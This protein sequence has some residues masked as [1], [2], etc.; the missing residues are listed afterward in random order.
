[1]INYIL[2]LIDKYKIYIK[3][4]ISGGTAAFV[5]LVLLYILTDIFGIWYLASASLA[6][7]VAFFVSFYLQKFWTFRDSSRDRM[8]QQMSIY[9]AVG[10]TNVGI[11]A[12]GM[13][14]LVDILG[15]MYI[16]AQIIMGGLIAIGSFLMYKFVIF[17]K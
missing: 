4:I 2:K 16:I 9:M 3:Y 5:D 12:G 14:V 15:I 6:F 1:M 10:L 17:K 7:L 13:Y 11:N 8:Y